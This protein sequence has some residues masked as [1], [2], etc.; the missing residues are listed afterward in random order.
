MS[1]SSGYRKYDDNECS[2][3][4]PPVPGEESRVR[5]VC[6]HCLHVFKISAYVFTYVWK[7]DDRRG[8]RS[9]A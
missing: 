5:K 8:G 3:P 4:R 9:Y 1:H 7:I 2:G 6:T